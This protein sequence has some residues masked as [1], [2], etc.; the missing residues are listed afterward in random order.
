MY[1]RS[2]I[3]IVTSHS[4]NQGSNITWSP[5]IIDLPLPQPPYHTQGGLI[6]TLSK[7]PLQSVTIGGT[8]LRRP[9]AKHTAQSSAPA[10]SWIQ[11]GGTPC[12]HA[13]KVPWRSTATIPKPVCRMNLLYSSK[14][15]PS[16]N[17]L[18]FSASLPDGSGMTKVKVSW[19]GLAGAL[20]FSTKRPRVCNSSCGR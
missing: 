6:G 18:K 9:R 17:H 12:P 8:E 16:T 2:A 19:V 3:A 4:H 13:T 7:M 14:R 1:M 15:D 10:A 5:V 20:T 11:R